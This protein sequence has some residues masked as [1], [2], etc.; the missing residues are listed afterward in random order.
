M[1]KV[2]PLS[3]GESKIDAQIEMIPLS[4]LLEES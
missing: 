1:T 4:L 3:V 2:I